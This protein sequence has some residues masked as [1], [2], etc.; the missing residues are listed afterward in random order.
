MADPVRGDAITPSCAFVRIADF[1]G[2]FDMVGVSPT[3]PA[4]DHFYIFIV[5]LCRVNIC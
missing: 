3:W 5:G 2:D 1:G 4:I